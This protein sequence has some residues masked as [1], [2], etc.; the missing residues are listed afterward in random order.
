MVL[1]EEMNEDFGRVLGCKWQVA[2]KKPSQA[3]KALKKQK[4]E[5][6]LKSP[7]EAAEAVNGMTRPA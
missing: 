5:L 7:F 1:Q 3:A 4:H 6:Q 2:A